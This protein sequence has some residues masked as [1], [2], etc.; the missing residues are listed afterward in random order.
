MV[1]RRHLLIAGAAVGG[2]LIVGFRPQ[3]MELEAHLRRAPP[4]GDPGWIRI[5]RDG[6]VR[7]YCTLTE[8]GQGAWSAL[9]Q[10]VNE[11]LD[12]D[13]D[14]LRVEM[15]PT[16]RAYAA[17]VG[18][19]T[20]GSTAVERMFDPMRVIGAAGRI[21]LI[22]AAASRWKVPSQSC[23]TSRG[24][25]FHDPTGQR[26]PYEELAA[27][28]ATF[29]VP[30]DPPLKPRSAWRS[31]GRSLPRLEAR[32]KIDGTATYG[33]D[34][35]LEGMLIAAVAQSPWPGARPQAIDRQAALRQPGVVRLIELDDT[36][37][38]LARNSWS[39]LRGLEAGSVSW[40]APEQVPD[41]ER[42]RTAL[43]E[44]VGAEPTASHSP[45]GTLVSATYDVPLLMHAQIEP[46]NATARVHRFG[47]ELWAPTQEPAVMQREV[48][49]ALLVPPQAVTVHTTLV[50]GGF[51]RRLITD[52]GVT[53]ARIA[54][55]AGVPVKAIWSREEDSAQDHFRPMAAARL[56][57]ALDADGMPRE[58][59]ATIA[60]L[61]E[62]PR[63]VGLDRSPYR[64]GSARVQY[65]GLTPAIRAGFWRSV[66]ASQNVFFRECFLDECAHAAGVDP[67]E[68]RLRL[69]DEDH[70]RG[71]RVLIA[72]R[73]ACAWT[74]PR[75]PDRFLGLAY[76]EGFGSIAAQAVEISR[77][78]SAGLRIERIVAAVDCGT[79]VNPGNIRAQI[80]GGA[81][82][83]LSAALRE[84]AV[85]E[86]GR[87]TRRNFDGY[88]VLRMADARPVEVH[89]LETPQSPI[90]GMG[91]VAVPPLAPA[92]ANALFAATG[93]R[94]R[95]LPLS[96]YA[97][98]WR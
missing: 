49:R 80:E 26:A 32:S 93:V 46:L 54:Q 31:I 79:A 92:L 8:M 66:D 67:L 77:S 2:G 20:G 74:S 55:K 85:F 87:L 43:L 48:A 89:I 6:S 50:G 34:V 15:A 44:R 78:A 62:R 51:G 84:E 25:V 76:N 38:V 97:L 19:G 28:A 98:D 57:A 29:R 47:A 37:A 86:E 16:W 63:T 27:L 60:G 40:R 59:N 9:A 3:M 33:L 64:L 88:P 69:L 52:E 41:T 10:L 23:R 18:F 45:D 91:E 5:D 39:A 94:A 22:E 13:P 7:L 1:T 70:A 11:E 71:R 61:G 65:F 35:R 58:F 24:E 4:L 81:L 36:V 12:A 96:H 75:R 90:G 72:L 82:F 95:R 83:A 14:R 68:Y 53:A 21:L 17:P 56:E 42:L 30:S 73:E